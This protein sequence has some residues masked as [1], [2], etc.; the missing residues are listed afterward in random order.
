MFIEA[1]PIRIDQ[2]RRGG[3]RGGRAEAEHLAPGVAAQPVKR[4]ADGRAGDHERPG[5]ET[6]MQV[7]PRDHDERDNQKERAVAGLPVA[8]AGTQENHHAQNGEN[9]R[10]RMPMDH[11]HARRQDGS[12]HRRQRR[13]PPRDQVRTEQGVGQGQHQRRG[14]HR[15][16]P[17]DVIDHRRQSEIEEPGLID[18][19]LIGARRAQSI[20]GRR[21]AGFPDFLAKLEM[22]KD[23]GVA[24]EELAAAAERHDQHGGEGQ[25]GRGEPQPRRAIHRAVPRS[26]IETPPTNASFNRGHT[27]P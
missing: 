1:E 24:Q 21:G 26:R 16:G 20:D 5:Q 25:I 22:P 18:P 2:R 14:Q 13:P 7:R 17:A 15:A 8:A 4:L 10:A 19:G 23:T 6:A 12:R 11:A 3:D 27:E 9:V